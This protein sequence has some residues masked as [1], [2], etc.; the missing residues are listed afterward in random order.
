M[1]RIIPPIRDLLKNPNISDNI[2]IEFIKLIT[3]P[4]EIPYVQHKYSRKVDLRNYPFSSNLYGSYIMNSENYTV[5]LQ[6]KNNVLG[7]PRLTFKAFLKNFAKGFKSGYFNFDK[8]I[9]EEN[10][11]VFKTKVDQASIIYDYASM[12]YPSLLHY[13]LNES[14][15][16]NYSAMFDNGIKRGYHYRA[17]YLILKNHKSF[18]DFFIKSDIEDD[19]T[20]LTFKPKSDIEDESTELTF[21]PKD[22]NINDW[23]LSDNSKSFLETEVML[24]KRG[25]IDDGY[26]W[27][28]SK[29]SS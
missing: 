4:D 10:T 20:E 12:P 25:Y 9:I 2:L 26:Q 11:E 7:M 1:A 15:N 3:P 6:R 14:V 21:K 22:E 28:D 29:R 18:E 24:F 5:R 19:S 23:I 16:K 27:Q 8:H 13:H 17:W